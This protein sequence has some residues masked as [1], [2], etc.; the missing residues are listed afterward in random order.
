MKHFFLIIAPLREVKEGVCSSF[1][2]ALAIID[3]KIVT[4]KFLSSTDLFG[5]QTLCVYK[6]ME[7]DVVDEYKYIMLRPFEV[8]PSSLEGL[9]NGQKLT[10]MSLIF[11]LR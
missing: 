7:V 2:L 8:V 1:C 10:I 5:A 6:P 9:N 3:L 11:G 4:N